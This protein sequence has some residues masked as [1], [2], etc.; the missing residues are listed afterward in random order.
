MTTTTLPDGA[1]VARIINGGVYLTGAGGIIIL[2]AVVVTAIMAGLLAM[3]FVPSSLTPSRNQA[4]M[5]PAV[6]TPD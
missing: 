5:Q 3:A 4:T 1:A 6:P 2:I